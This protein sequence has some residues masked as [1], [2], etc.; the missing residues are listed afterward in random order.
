M[1]SPHAPY[2]EGTEEQPLPLFH[3]RHHPKVTVSLPSPIFSEIL[4][5]QAQGVTGF[6]YD[7]FLSSLKSAAKTA[8]QISVM[9]AGM[10]K[11]IV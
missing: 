5:Q 1:P 7:V 9:M 2:G 6:A 11:T 10:V 3:C 8:V 4:P